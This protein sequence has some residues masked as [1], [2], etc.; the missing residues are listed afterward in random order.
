M[1]GRKI[2]YLRHKFTVPAFWV[3]FFPH[4]FVHIF[5]SQLKYFTSPT[6]SSIPGWRHERQ[7]SGEN[8]KISA[9][10]SPDY[11]RT[12]QAMDRCQKL[13]PTTIAQR[14]T[15]WDFLFNL[16]R[17][18]HGSSS[19]KETFSDTMLQGGP[20]QSNHSFFMYNKI[21]H[22]SMKYHSPKLF[23]GVFIGELAFQLPKHTVV[24][25]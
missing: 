19:P 11:A 17:I 23:L 13:T 20:P 7:L 24:Q 16:A 6:C 25:W 22:K 5:G 1:L 8:K 2:S 3:C 18:F 15:V 10:V 14:L 9:R 4:Y 12:W 21:N